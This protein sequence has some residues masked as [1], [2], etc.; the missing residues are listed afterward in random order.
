MNE[1]SP[2]QPEGGLTL[3]NDTRLLQ[4]H[5]N[6]IVQGNLKVEFKSVEKFIEEA[7]NKFLVNRTR[8]MTTMA[9]E[10]E[11]TNGNGSIELIGVFTN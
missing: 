3:G 2:R 6:K 7:V 9:E 11:G 10:Q 8:T 1:D 5:I 4:H